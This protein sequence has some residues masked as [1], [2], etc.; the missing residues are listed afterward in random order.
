VLL[1]IFVFE[2]FD[3]ELFVSI[4]LVCSTGLVCC[5]VIEGWFG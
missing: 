5:I 4:V 1:V 3:F 2:V